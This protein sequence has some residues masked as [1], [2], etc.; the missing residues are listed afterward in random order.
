MAYEFKGKRALV[1]GAASGIGRAVALQLARDG[2][3]L[4]LTDLNA[5]G[6]AEIALDQM[7]HLGGHGVHRDVHPQRRP[8]ARAL[9]P[10]RRQI[11]PRERLDQPREHAGFGHS[12]NGEANRRELTDKGPGRGGGGHGETP[13]HE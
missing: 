3:L 8:A 10:I 13:K 2:A 12:E 5:D 11:A 4:Y 6:L 7:N 1:T 9:E